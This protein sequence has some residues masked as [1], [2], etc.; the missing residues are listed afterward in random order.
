MRDGARASRRYYETHTSEVIKQK[1]LFKV[2]ENGRI[3]R[4]TTMRKH[5]ICKQ[6]VDGALR[7]YAER[8]PETAAARRIMNRSVGNVTI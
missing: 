7:E 2:R 1:T 6:Q 4:D 5:G 3:P 8:H